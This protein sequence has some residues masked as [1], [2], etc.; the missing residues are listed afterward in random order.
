MR[1]YKW[2]SFQ[3]QQN[4]TNAWRDYL[5]SPPPNP[6]GWYGLVKEQYDKQLLSEGITRDPLDDP[7]LLEELFGRKRGWEREVEKFEKEDAEKAAAAKAGR[8][9]GGKAKAGGADW[10]AAVAQGSRGATE[11]GEYKATWWEKAKGVMAKMGTLEKSGKMGISWLPGGENRAK[12]EAYADAKE[13]LA[14]AAEKAASQLINRDLSALMKQK[15]PK[16][17]NMTTT[18]EFNDA[19][20]DIGTI[21]DSVVA[22]TEKDPQDEEYLDPVSANYL[23]AYLREYVQYNLD[24]ELSDVGKH[25]IEENEELE[26]AAPPRGGVADVP[27]TPTPTRR[28]GQVGRP[29]SGQADY[30]APEGPKGRYTRHAAVKGR[31]SDASTTIQGLKSN[32]LPA[33]LGYLGAAAGG[34]AGYVAMTTNVPPP[35]PG[36]ADEEIWKTVSQSVETN[37]NLAADPNGTLAMFANGAGDPQNFQ[38]IAGNID[39]IAAAGG[40]TPDE[41]ISTYSDVAMMGEESEVALKA[42]YEW[43]KQGGD[44]SAWGA[45]GGVPTAEFQEFVTSNPA[46]KDIHEYVSQTGF[47][48]GTGVASD[49]AGMAGGGFGNTWGDLA[50]TVEKFSPEQMQKMTDTANELAK[51][52]GAER[53]EFTPEM[54]LKQIENAKVGGRLD[55]NILAAEDPAS[56]ASNLSHILGVSANNAMGGEAGGSGMERLLG[57]NAETVMSVGSTVSTITFKVFMGMGTRAAAAAAGAGAAGALGIGAAAAPIL[58]ALGI[59]GITG[60]IAVKLIRMKGLHSSRAQM[61][62]ILLDEMPDVAVPPTPVPVKPPKPIKP[63]DPTDPCADQPGTTWS[64]ELQKCVPGED[65]GPGPVP[66]KPPKPGPGE[67]E[68]YTVPVYGRGKTVEAWVKKWG[69]QNG[70]RPSTKGME[71]F[72]EVLEKWMHD[73][74]TTHKDSQFLNLRERDTNYDPGP[75][76]G[77]TTD[78]GPGRMD[79]TDPGTGDDEGG[80]EQRPR[81]VVYVVK[82]RTKSRRGKSLMRRIYNL[83]LTGAGSGGGYGGSPFTKPMEKQ[84]ALQFAKGLGKFVKDDLEKQGAHVQQEGKKASR[85]PLKESKRRALKEAKEN[86]AWST[87][88]NRWK[89]LSGIK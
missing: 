67:E 73:V 17:P 34:A 16:F 88:T 63:V 43:G 5:N 4:Y 78:A 40:I 79:A 60:G 39:K 46:F 66:P 89:E 45:G 86:E 49:V 2:S 61:M 71:E 28:S 72:L 58:G 70:F 51:G 56:G 18:E 75:G 10:G 84:Q 13:K 30:A 82:N 3:K 26:E 31:A 65:P 20:L 68:R 24:N 6:H 36:M 9:P 41:V 62:G 69:R 29:A 14:A 76:P 85:Q 15:Y 21:Y 35:E 54:I 27:T 37:V 8:T 48:A 25:A 1:T 38:D 81:R 42:V 83:L 77:W 23:I 22:S 19:L 59:A 53:M 32:T 55:V 52:L 50:N 47:G 80:E 44:I 57:L 11:P 12:G 64:D 7:E 33:I 87:L 74:E